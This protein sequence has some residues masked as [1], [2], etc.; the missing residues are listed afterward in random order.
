MMAVRDNDR[1]GSS[2]FAALMS[3][4]TASVAV[5]TSLQ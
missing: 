2:A 3:E 5:A 4:T 1:D